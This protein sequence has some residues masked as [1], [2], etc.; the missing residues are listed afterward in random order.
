M[1]FATTWMVL[2]GIML[3]EVHWK[4]KDRYRMISLTCGNSRYIIRVQQMAKG[5]NKRDSTQN[6]A[7]G[8]GAWELSRRTLVK[9]VLDEYPSSGCEVDMIYA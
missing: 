4:E 1:Q 8:M 6:L 3:S 2:E 5:K 9:G 7:Y